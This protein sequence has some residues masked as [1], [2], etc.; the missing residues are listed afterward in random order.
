VPSDESRLRI[1]VMA[2]LTTAHIDT[3][4]TAI[5]RVSRRFGFHPDQVM[6]W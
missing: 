3:A 2:T 4:V 1:S 5:D 6:P